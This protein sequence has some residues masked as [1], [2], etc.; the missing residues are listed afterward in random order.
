MIIQVEK[1]EHIVDYCTLCERE[2][3]ENCKKCKEYTNGMFTQDI[4]GVTYYHGFREDKSH[5]SI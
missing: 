4:C 5:D 3:D 1:G 2:C